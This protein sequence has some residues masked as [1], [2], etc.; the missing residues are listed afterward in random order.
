MWGYARGRTRV[1]YAIRGRAAGERLVCLTAL[2]G[3]GT[4]NETTSVSCQKPTFDR[5][6][7]HP[8]SSSR[9]ESYVQ[10]FGSTK[11]AREGPGLNG[12]PKY[13]V[14]RATFPSL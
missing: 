5:T 9:G 3:F 1:S 14:S 2:T 4:R 8:L 6:S 10:S 11:C 13:C 12:S 7:P